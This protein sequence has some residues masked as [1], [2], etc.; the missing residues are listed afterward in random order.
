MLE[1]HYGMTV[2]TKIEVPGCVCVCVCDPGRHV[3]TK[4]LA[5]VVVNVLQQSRV[6]FTLLH[7]DTAVLLVRCLM[8]DDKQVCVKISLV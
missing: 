6:F 4:C 1:V 2:P 3:Q 8:L 5:S 7:T